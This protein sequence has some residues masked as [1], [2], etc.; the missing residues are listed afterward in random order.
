MTVFECEDCVDGI[1]TA[2][3]DAWASR[4][5]HANV[6]LQTGNTDTLCLFCTYRRVETDAQKAEKV[7][8]TIRRRMGTEAYES[9]YRA[10]LARD[11]KKA[12]SIYRVLVQGLSAGL[13]AREASAVIH[14]IQDPDVCRVFELARKVGHEAHRYLGFVRFRELENGVLF[15][16]IRAEAN[17][18]PLIG[19]HFADRFPNENFMIYDHG[20]Q[21]CLVHRAGGPWVIFWDMQPDESS[22]MRLS[23]HEQEMQR[24]WKGFCESVSIKERENPRCQQ[25]LWPLKFRKWMTE[26]SGGTEFSPCPNSRIT[27]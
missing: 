14:R 27:V 9:V 1:F 4:L 24:L 3:Y 26:G 2:V 15:S 6:Y 5:G 12:D 13:S 20:H 10:A 8:R 19:T 18:L 22:S 17:V 16:E 21:A 25:Q 23:E 11:E 7:A